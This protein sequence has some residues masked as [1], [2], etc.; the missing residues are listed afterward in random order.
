MQKQFKING[1]EI[2]LEEVNEKTVVTINT[3]DADIIVNGSTIWSK[4]DK[5]EYMDIPSVL[6]RFIYGK[7]DYLKVEEELV[8]VD[9]LLPNTYTCATFLIPKNKQKPVSVRFDFITSIE[10]LE[11]GF[12]RNKKILM[13][14]LLTN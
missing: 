12:I 13:M 6:R 2:I 5:P 8:T 3:E 9:C 11:F 7:Q 10:E 14:R 1:T 4:Y